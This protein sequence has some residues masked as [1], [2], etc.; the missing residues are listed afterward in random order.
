MLHF[1]HRSS[2]SKTVKPSNYSVK[3][4]LILAL[5]LG[6]CSPS[7]TN[8][9]LKTDLQNTK[10]AWLNSKPVQD[11]YY[12]GIGHSNKDG[13]NNYIQSAKQSALEDMVSEI[14]VNIS[15]TSVKRLT[16]SRR[17]LLRARSVR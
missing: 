13:L 8:T 14:R 15:S 12:V 3:Q 11:S 1:W 10:P 16:F 6:G 9:G 4:I 2:L 5:L 17:A 7:L